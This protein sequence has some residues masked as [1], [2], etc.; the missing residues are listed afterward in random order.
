[1]SMQL[2]EKDIIA[3]LESK[4][5]NEAQIEQLLQIVRTT[6][7]SIQNKKHTK[8]RVPKTAKMVASMLEELH[9]P[10]CQKNESIT[11][12]GH[13]YQTDSTQ[14]RF[15]CDETLVVDA[16]TKVKKVKSITT[17]RLCDNCQRKETIIRDIEQ[18]LK[19]PNNHKKIQTFIK[20]LSSEV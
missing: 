19:E 15:V 5:L 4:G 10:S 13:F 3:K 8:S 20:Q 12:Y 9:C 7:Q 16:L 17:Y 1:M 18:L 2:P 11:H 14:S 6:Q